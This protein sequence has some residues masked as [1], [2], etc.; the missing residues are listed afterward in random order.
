MGG[1]IGLAIV[2]TIL[3]SYVKSHLADILS[4]VQIQALLRTTEAFATLPPDVA[5]TARTVFGNG[6]N[7]QMRIMIGFSAA[8]IP[9]VLLMWQK[10]QIVI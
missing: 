10:K 6:F 5:E 2:T 7:L 3:N 4:P 1:A 9:T 8:Q